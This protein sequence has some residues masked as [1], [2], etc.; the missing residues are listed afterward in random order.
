M[1]AGYTKTKTR[2]ADP[3]L[4]N[5]G[6][7]KSS[8]LYFFNFPKFPLYGSIP[9]R[10]TYSLYNIPYLCI[11]HN[12]FGITLPILCSRYS[13]YWT[14]VRKE[15]YFMVDFQNIVRLYIKSQCNQGTFTNKQLIH[16]DSA[17]SLLKAISYCYLTRNIKFPCPW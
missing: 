12:I 9:L 16:D 7:S 5:E 8:T 3:Y 15:S 2:I 13:K 1:D 10:L 6:A 17:I 14:V 4:P 11:S